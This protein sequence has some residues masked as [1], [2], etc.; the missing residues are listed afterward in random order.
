LTGKEVGNSHIGKQ[1]GK[2]PRSKITPLPQEL[3]QRKGRSWR[4]LFLLFVESGQNLS[5]AIHAAMGAHDV[6]QFHFTAVVAGNKLD[7]F[8]TVVGATIVAATL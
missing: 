7:R 1:K 6:C 4:P 8:D 2:E 5:A 3:W